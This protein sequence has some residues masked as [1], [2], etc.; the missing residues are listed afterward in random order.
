[1]PR[2]SARAPTLPES[3]RGRAIN[4]DWR[5]GLT[6]AERLEAVG[7]TLRPI[8]KLSGRRR[9]HWR[10]ERRADIARA[11]KLASPRAVEP[12]WWR[13][14]W[15]VYSAAAP[16]SA[17]SGF[18]AALGPFIAPKTASLRAQLSS[19][20]CSF[21]SASERSRQE[22]VSNFE[23][24]L[25][26]RLALAVTKTLVL[27]LAVASRARLLKG[28][29]PQ[30][31][32][33]F[34]CECLKD[35]GFAAR[36]LA[37]YPLL[38]RR[39]IA[40]AANW[41]QASM[42]LLARIAAAEA[43]LISIFFPNEHP[44]PLISVEASGDVHGRG[45]ATHV[46]SF[47]SGAKLVYKPRQMAM[48]RCYYEFVAWLNDY[49][50]D[51]RLKVVRTL[52]E[53]AFGWM[54]FVPVAPCDTPAEV[55]R[56]FAR[57]G[58]HLAL[59]SL[60][61]GTDLHS[62]NVIAHGEHPVPV[63][64]ETLFHAD[65]L[66][67]NL[68]G[69]TA[70][71]WAELRHSVVRTVMLPEARGFTDKPEDWVDMSA[72]GHGDDQLTP[73]PV[74]NWVRA[75]TDRMRL[76]Y[77]RKTIPMGFSLP[78]FSGQRV[79]SVSYADDVVQGFVHAYELVRKFKGELLGPQGPLST[80]AGKSAR[81]VFRDTAIYGLTLSASFHP[82]FQRDAIA[83]EAM[84]RDALRASAADGQ[85][86]L[87][88]LEDAEAADLLAC[89]PIHGQ[90]AI[91]LTGSTGSWPRIEAMNERDLERQAWLIR[92]AMQDPSK[93]TVA[94]TI[95]LAKSPDTPSAQTLVA[96]AARIGDRICELAIEDGDRC[97]WLVP[98]LVNLRRLGATVAGFD[99]YDGL[100]GIALFLA[101]LS[102]ITG[103][104]RYGRL[105]DAG[106]R[107]A[108]A[109]CRKQTTGLAKLGAFQGVGGLCYALVHL[110]AV[111]GRDELAADAS[112]IIRR[113][114]KR[115]ARTADLDLITGAAG[116]VVAGLAVARFNQDRALVDNLRPAAERLYRLTTS[117][118]RALPILKESETGLAH[119]R[120]GAALALLRWAEATGE[121]RSRTAGEDL[122][123]KDFAIMEA[124]R[125]NVSAKNAAEHPADYLGWCRGSLGIAMAALGTR[126]P[127]IDLLD[128]A[129]AKGFEQEMARP[130]PSRP[131]CLCH[132]ALGWL[133]FLGFA[134]RR[135]F[136]EDRM[137][138]LDAWRTG[139][140]HEILGGRWVADWA[141]A[142]ES[143]SLMLGL[144][145]T[146]YSLLRQ[147]AAN[148]VP[149]VLLLEDA[150]VG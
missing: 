97:T 130:R 144:A 149:S 63:D 31:R 119:G 93:E 75:E 30:A 44:G 108:R 41:E 8:S 9:M 59:T 79:Q 55:S 37:Q 48:E 105:A 64:L 98:E 42:N 104:E 50:L 60:L 78:E 133:E 141:H 134:D 52:E 120:A 125:R 58:A 33:S 56:F 102:A 11:R 26:D 43:K 23:E 137:K 16:P 72:L 4:D 71:G 57:M 24:T 86:W 136:G 140:L 85:P 107:E 103:E 115:A 53:G 128:A 112:A 17:E 146:G 88:R 127:V 83:C 19:G 116:F 124:A 13:E 34:F 61:G 101:Q 122:L 91:A 80:F 135:L 51:P 35:P 129:W 143:P 14:F 95:D 65:P 147:A 5:L 49:G 84:L 150:A 54:E 10:E 1:M 6:L 121:T 100:P 62:E 15:D 2:T 32:F 74:A 40:I 148:R 92:V 46:L 145:G 82:R 36:L 117:S 66:P 68:S 114:A 3:A 111:T 70:R 118:R 12:P 96:A 109:L 45:Q 87:K 29:T 106:M 76:I 110:A 73:M 38:V 69:A 28:D 139:L 18:L 131:L 99:L 25:R 94:A 77:E 81:R 142:L 138:Q 123:R 47:G 20:G 21:Y 39:C 67:E 113:F 27:E 132:G 126:P 22:L 90:A 7:G 89:C